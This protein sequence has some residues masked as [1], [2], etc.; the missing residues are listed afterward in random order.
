MVSKGGKI[1]ISLVVV[2]VVAVAWITWC[3]WRKRLA[4]RKSQ[5]IK[6]ALTEKTC[7]HI[8]EEY[9]ASS[10]IDEEYDESYKESDYNNLG[11]HHSKL[12]VHKCTSGTCKTC[13]PVGDAPSLHFV[14][15]KKQVLKEEEA[16]KEEAEP[17]PDFQNH[18]DVT[19]FPSDMDGEPESVEIEP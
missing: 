14:T 12:N 13:N 19:L 7:V 15:L 8:D 16:L 3:V 4:E 6:P 10:H 18:L 9:D 11:S 1:I 5:C 17:L 2:L